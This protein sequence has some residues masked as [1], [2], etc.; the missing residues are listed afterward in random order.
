MHWNVEADGLRVWIPKKH[1]NT[2]I[3]T[4]MLADLGGFNCFKKF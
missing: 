4:L 2:S 1:Y 3:N